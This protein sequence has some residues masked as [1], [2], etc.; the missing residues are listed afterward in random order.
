MDNQFAD[1]HRLRAHR[2][3]KRGERVVQTLPE[4]PNV[5]TSGFDAG[6]LY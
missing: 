3:K 6:K 1:Y 2:M 4:S 5:P